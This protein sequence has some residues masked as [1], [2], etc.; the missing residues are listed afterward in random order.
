MVRLEK[1]FLSSN[2]QSALP[3]IDFIDTFATTN[4][5]DDL[6][7]ITTLILTTMPNW[8]SALFKLRNFLVQFVGLKV[9][10]PKDYHSQFKVGGHI[11]FF[12]IYAIYNNEVI[13]GANDSHLNFRLSIY[14][15]KEETYNIKATTLVQYNNKL[16]Y[17]YMMIIK[18]FHML[19]VRQMVK[20][21]YNTN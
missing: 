19:V 17:I 10:P 18:P 4:H 5:I 16:G 7:K 20:Q 12:Q 1:N 3:K 14:N 15:T 6:A 11:G 13:L 21:A 2:A 8:V 9:S